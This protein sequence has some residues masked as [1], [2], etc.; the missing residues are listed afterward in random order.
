MS[1]GDQ[2]RTQFF[3]QRPFAKKIGAQFRVST[4]I[5][6]HP[7]SSLFIHV[8]AAIWGLNINYLDLSSIFTKG[9]NI[10]SIISF[11]F[12]FIC[13]C[14]IHFIGTALVSLLELDPVMEATTPMDPLGMLMSECVARI[15]KKTREQTPTKL[16]YHLQ[17]LMNLFNVDAVPVREKM[18]RI[19][20]IF[21][22]AFSTTNW[23]QTLMMNAMKVTPKSI[24]TFWRNYPMSTM[25]KISISEKMVDPFWS[26]TVIPSE[27][28]QHLFTKEGILFSLR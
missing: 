24:S 12:C 17:S 9:N 7:F 15:M 6:P 27:I 8:V 1:G 16:M 4:K 3:G 23:S 28:F 10:P 2:T 20:M 26:R 14:K 25:M 11:V 19:L 5:R 22:S 21:T 18:I 13:Y